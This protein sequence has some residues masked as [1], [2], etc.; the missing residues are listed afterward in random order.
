M[1]LGIKNKKVLITGASQGIGKEIALA[2]AKEGCKVS[3]M[4]RRKK[5]LEK[6][7]EEMGG[8]GQGHDYCVTDL[9]KL[10]APTKAIKY[11]FNKNKNYDIAIHNLGGTLEVRDP[12]SVV[13]DYAKV[14]NFNV[15]VAIEMNNLLIPKMQEQKWGRI[16]HI[17]SLTAEHVRG[18]AAYGPAKAYLN[19]YTKILG[20]KFAKDGIVIS[21]LMPCSIYAEG[22]HWDPESE[23]NIKNKESFFK[24]RDDFLKHYQ[25]RGKL[26]EANE[27]APFALFMASKYVTLASASIIPIGATELLGL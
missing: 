2:F 17:S 8:Q 27:I 24:K 10:G 4:A 19:A 13:E 26:G 14:W 5:E 7:V 22:G 1:D 9:M 12:L 6:V 11:F 18:C 23:E 15:G 21:A 3:I 20:K 16:I 25:P